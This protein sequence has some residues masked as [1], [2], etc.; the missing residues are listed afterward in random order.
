VYLPHNTAQ[1][2][3]TDKASRFV[4]NLWLGAGLFRQKSCWRDFNLELSDLIFM[5]A[6]TPPDAVADQK[7]DSDTMRG[8]AI[9]RAGVAGMA[10]AAMTTAC[11]AAKTLHVQKAPFGQTA[12]GE[13]V[14][15]YTL[16]NKHG[17][18]ARIM[19]YG[20][21]IVS[22]KT[23]D[24]S[25][26][27]EDI[28]LGFDTLDPYLAGVPYFGATIGRYGNR[29]ANGSF[30]LD[31]VTYQLPKNNG[32]NSLHGGDKGFD[33]RLWTAKPF[34]TKQGPGLKLSY[35]SADG[36]EGY[37]GQLTAHVTY[38]LHSN[39]TLSI[40]YQATTTKPTVVNLT[41]HSYFNLSGSVKRD[42]LG[43]LLT[44][45][46]DKY[47]PV[48]ATLIPTGELAAVAGTPFDFRKATAIGAR[49]DADNEQIHF[50][51]GYDHNWVL[52][53]PKPG[54][55]TTAAVLSDPESGRVMEIK[56]TEPGLQFYSGNFLDGKPSG[57]GTVF[58]HRTGLC[59]ETQHFPDAPNE[60]TFPSTTL[61]PGHTYTSHTVLIFRTAK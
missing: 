60:P 10:L 14:Q 58:K 19:T 11:W 52:V 17:I 12:S 53:K 34:E 47:T 59:L 2:Q 23:P 41:N 56:T 20:G 3:Q 1:V 36:E 39:N 45:N 24:R 46:A 43:E 8:I 29:I 26:K 16:T 4:P 54:A 38:Q 40:D 25:G 31:G 61:R 49:I 21:T 35:V 15:I 27:L 44:I 42:I 37:P 51:P 48:N 32:P 9:L 30:V 13:A 6:A 22:L 7:E 33:K 18:E 50:G 57:Q 55:M 28:V 5:P